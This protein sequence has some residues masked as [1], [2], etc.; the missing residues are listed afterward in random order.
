MLTRLA[1]LLALA[2]SLA[3]PAGAQ[4]FQRDMTVTAYCPCGSCNGYT[5]G[6]W[7]MLKLDRWNRYVSE[8][9]GQGERYTGKTAAGEKLRTAK[10]G[11]FS[12]D[13][14]QH[15]LRIPGR[16][17]MPWNALRR[18]GTI[19]ADTDYYAFGTR[20]YVPGWGWGVVTDRGGAIKGPE[21]IDIFLRTHG[22]TEQWGRQRLT[23]TVAQ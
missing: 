2:C 15:P 17:L 8:G 6:S 16:V 14:L 18:Y 13:S 5:R 22:A 12:K 3:L 9:R 21:R 1:L 7:K 23:V 10:A 20:M 4:S 11:L 19:A